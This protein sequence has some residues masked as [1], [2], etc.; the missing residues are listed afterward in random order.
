M[1][2]AAP[3]PDDLFGG[4]PR[5]YSFSDIK[6]TPYQ[7]YFLRAMLFDESGNAYNQ[8]TAGVSA[9]VVANRNKFGFVAYPALYGETGRRTF[10]ISQRGTVYHK[11]MGS[12]AAKIV[13][14][15]PGE[16]PKEHGWEWVE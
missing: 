1:A 16:D 3:A 2:D 10:I 4:E 9:V 12:D 13:L 11:D 15:W 6:P 14:H 5:L 8:V 7:G